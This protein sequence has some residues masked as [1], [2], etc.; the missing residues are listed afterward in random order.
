M[1]LKYNIL[2]SSILKKYHHDITYTLGIESN[3]RAWKNRY[4][5]YIQY[6]SF[7]FS[8][9]IWVTHTRVLKY[10]CIKVLYSRYLVY[11]IIFL[12]NIKYIPVL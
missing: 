5:Y 2:Y 8:T 7:I 11:V 10:S 12:L 1:I 4:L 6:L 9:F 3:V